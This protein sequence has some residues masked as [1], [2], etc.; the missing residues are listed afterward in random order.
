VYAPEL[1]HDPLGKLVAKPSSRVRFGFRSGTK[2][3]IG[4]RQLL[5]GLNI[6]EN[7]NP[8]FQAHNKRSSRLAVLLSHRNIVVVSPHLFCINLNLRAWLQT[9]RRRGDSAGLD[10]PARPG[11]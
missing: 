4:K 3:C 9:A 8:E 7:Y 1:K 5:D 11:T 2:R 10:R 6:N